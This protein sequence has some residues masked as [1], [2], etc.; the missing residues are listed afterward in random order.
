MSPQKPKPLAPEGLRKEPAAF[1][2]PLPVPI[3][4]KALLSQSLRRFSAVPLRQKRQV[5]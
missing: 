2:P 1:L 5:K 4:R 3:V